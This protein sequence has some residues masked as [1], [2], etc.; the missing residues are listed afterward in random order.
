MSANKRS[1]RALRELGVYG[2]DQVEPVVLAALVTGDPLLLIGKAG[3]GKTFLLNSLSEALGLEHRHYN[4]SLIAFDDLVGFPYPENDGESIRYIETPATVWQAQSVLI[5]EISRCKPEHQNRLF[6]LVHERRVQGLPLK[7]LQYRWAAMNPCSADQGVDDFYDG[8]VPLDQALADRFAFVIEVPDWSDLK[9]KDRKLIAD[10][11]G[12]GAPS[13]VSK[14][15]CDF[16]AGCRASLPEVR[17]CWSKA[18]IAYASAAATELGKNRVRVSPRRARQLACNLVALTAVKGGAPA[19]NV[20]LLGLRH[21]LPQIAWGVRV[22]PGVVQAAHKIAW[23]HAFL[24]GEGKW[25]NELLLEPRLE[26]KVGKILSTSPDPDTGAVAVSRTLAELDPVSRAV[27]AFALYPAS[28]NGHARIGSEG[29]AALSM[30]AREIL[31]VDGEVSWQERRGLSGTKHPQLNECSRVLAKRRGARKSRA[32][33]VFYHLIVNGVPIENP[34][35]VE[36]ELNGCVRRVAA[37]LR[38]ENS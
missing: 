19:A 15:L 17:R 29:V 7:N 27:F 2:Y 38:K 14:S 8:S 10:P 5:D 28:L 30:V 24:E 12:E 23:D 21:S 13:P 16:I 32:R 35:R 22:E 9:E 20:F 1:P 31:E 25:L 37:C 34:E 18:V 33:Q 36:E 4:A 26:H 3:T 11:A 6:S